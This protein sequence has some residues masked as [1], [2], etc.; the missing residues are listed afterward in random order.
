VILVHG[1]FGC[2]KSYLLVAI[3]RFISTL[4]DQ[5]GNTDIKILVCALTNIAVDRILMM[6]KNSQFEDF[7][8]VGSLKKINKSLLSYTHHSSSN[9]KQA[10]KDALRELE[11]MKEE[12]RASIRGGKMTGSQY[13]ELM[14]LEASIQ[15]IKE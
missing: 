2:G 10:D 4:L 11:I 9:K 3:I 14:A 1:A 7:A 15:N 12:L 8:R 13:E 5:I 6:L